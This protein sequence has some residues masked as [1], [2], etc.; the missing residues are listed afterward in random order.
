M[1]HQLI[2]RQVSGNFAVSC[3]C[4]HTGTGLI[5]LR[6]EPIEIR[7]RWTVPEALAAWRAWH[8]REGI[9]I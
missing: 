4:R 3:L 8:E 1:P 2:T 9:T 5:R 6:C 7:S